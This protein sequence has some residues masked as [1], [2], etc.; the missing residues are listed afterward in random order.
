[1]KYSEGDKVILGEFE[2]TPRVNGVVLSGEELSW[3]I[4]YVVQVEPED[5]SD[6][7]LRELTEDQIEG[8]QLDS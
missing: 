5:A 6:D 2:G 1:M 4:S 7:G 3:G 8:Y